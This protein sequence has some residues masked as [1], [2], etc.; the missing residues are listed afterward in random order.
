MLKAPIPTS[1]IAPRQKRLR[2][3]EVLEEYVKDVLRDFNRYMTQ[4][5]VQAVPVDLN[6]YPNEHHFFSNELREDLLAKKF[7]GID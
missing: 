5:C 4:Q 2:K 3:G 7:D 1:D 6:L